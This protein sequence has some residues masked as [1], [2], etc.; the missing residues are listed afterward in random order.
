MENDKA[1]RY[2]SGK[3]KSMTVKTLMPQCHNATFNGYSI[4]MN[5]FGSHLNRK[6][7]SNIEFSGACLWCDFL[8]IFGFSVS[9]AWFLFVLVF[10]PS[11]FT[12][13]CIQNVSNWTQWTLRSRGCAQYNDFN[14]RSVWCGFEWMSNEWMNPPCFRFNY[15]VIVMFACF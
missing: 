5:C 4:Q 7:Q 14:M 12:C 1:D 9:F 6:C 2:N 3:P 10:A 15:A 8:L 13:S 11:M